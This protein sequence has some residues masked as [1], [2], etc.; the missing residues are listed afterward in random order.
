[1]TPTRVMSRPV[2]AVVLLALAS[3]G[4]GGD[5]E[6][7]LKTY[8]VQGTVKF[9]DGSPLGRG[10]IFFEG[11]RLQSKGALNADGTF[12][13]STYATDDGAPAGNYKIYILDAN[14]PHQGEGYGA[15]GPSLIDKKFTSMETSGLTREVKEGTNKFDDIVVEKPK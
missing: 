7:K 3:S 9:S 1:M 2:L 11:E 12:K 14:E 8:P 4:C 10:M 5:S 6:K 13:L 15:P